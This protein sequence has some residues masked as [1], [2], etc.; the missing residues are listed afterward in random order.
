V[1]AFP[2]SSHFESDGTDSCLIACAGGKLL[3]GSLDQLH[4]DYQEIEGDFTFTAHIAEAEGP[5]ADWQ[6]GVMLRESIAPGA[7]HAAM[8]LSKS[9]TGTRF[10][11]VRREVESSAS[12]GVTGDNATVP[13]A[14]VRMDRR[15]EEIVTSSSPD[16]MTWS[17]LN[18]AT[19]TGLPNTLLCGVVA[20]G[21]DLRPEE[22]FTPL[23]A[24]VCNLEITF[25]AD[26]VTFHRGD[27]N[28]SGTTDISDGIA[29]FGYLFL[30]NP[31]ALSCKESADTN[32][33]GAV[34]ISDGIAILQ[35]LFS[36]GPPP[37][38]PG[39]PEDPCG[40]DP[41]PIGSAADLG[42]DSS[43]QPCG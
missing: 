39:P 16:K 10:R 11:S 8:L 32:N 15:G 2:G 43:Y 33:S 23:M 29:I 7:R 14:W 30:G 36:D 3:A 4:F 41:D 34:D 40:L 28:S 25:Q 12:R 31:P 38:A 9:T 26:K 21:S 13:D 27:P 42:C 35:Y 22:A 6:V 5:A 1:P 20:M 37:V 24:R 19:F 18:R 17:E